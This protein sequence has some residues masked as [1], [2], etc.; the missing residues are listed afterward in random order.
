LTWAD[1]LVILTLIVAFWGGYRNGVVREAIGM[2]AIIIAWI[3]AGSFAGLMSP[4]MEKTFGLSQA[5]GHLA[6]FW[7]LFLFVFAATRAAGWAIE[8][9]TAKPVL[10]FASGIGGGFV[11]CAK[12][13]LALWLVLFI[14]LF[15]PIA[16]DVRATLK[17]SPTVTAIEALDRPVYAMLEESLPSRARPFARLFLDKHHL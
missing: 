16:Q 8:K 2:L 14:A 13:V 15:F 17:L 4:T 12:A 7:L 3:A 6:S 5:S 11:S 9:I 10:K 1:G